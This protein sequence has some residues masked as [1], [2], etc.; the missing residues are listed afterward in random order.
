M[1][2]WKKKTKTRK[3]VYVSPLVKGL[4]FKNLKSKVPPK[5]HDKKPEEVTQSQF[6]ALCSEDQDD[7]ETFIMATADKLLEL[8]F[9]W[10]EEKEHVADNLRKLA[11]KL[12]SLREKCNASECV[13]STVTMVGAVGLI[14]AGV[15]T[16]FTG[17]AASPLVALASAYTGIG[18]TI[19]LTTKIIEK[20]CSKT[21]E[22]VKDIEKKSNEIAKEIHQLFQK[23]KSE[24]KKVDPSSKPEELEHHIMIEFLR[25]IAR[26]IGVN[27]QI[28]NDSMLKDMLTHTLQ[29]FPLAKMN[30]DMPSCG[31]EGRSSSAGTGRRSEGHSGDWMSI[32]VIKKSPQMRQTHLEKHKM[33]R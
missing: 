12:E 27:V 7:T 32:S 20:Q 10:I 13:G 33:E 17:G 26:K 31:A 6:S 4:P 22:K 30:S 16:F 11:K 24:K 14:G 9:C 28:I 1:E 18:S 8:I 29:E 15:A 23:L 19:S 21:M 2:K 5:K 25:A 3:G